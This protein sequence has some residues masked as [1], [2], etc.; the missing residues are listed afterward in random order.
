MINIH[1][2]GDIVR[3][4]D[5]AEIHKRANE[6]REQRG[7]CKYHYNLITCQAWIDYKKNEPIGECRKDCH[8]SGCDDCPG[9]KQRKEIG[10][11]AK[12][13][14][15]DNTVYRKISSAAH[16]MVKDSKYKTIF[17]TLTFPPY[18]TKENEKLQNNAF[19]KFMENLH[20]NYGVK[21]YIAIRERGK[22]TNRLHYHLLCSI[23]FVDFTTLNRSWCNAISDISDFSINALS[24]KKQNV[25]I[26]NPGYALRYACKYFSKQRGY[27]SSTRIVFISNSLLSY[28]T[29]EI[30]DYSAR[31]EPI[32]KRISKI[33]KSVHVPVTSILT[34]YKN[35][36]IQ[37]TSD[38]ST[39]F[40]ITD[41]LE[42][43]RFCSDFLYLFF[44][45]ENKKAD[46]VGYPSE[47]S[48]S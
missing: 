32:Y 33:K 12:S 24:S 18:K 31:G 36:Y 35:I 8:L 45:L 17:I 4:P 15:I 5:I 9:Y 41:K 23:K 13:Y 21:Y 46:F 14:K 3:C 39:C 6:L 44:E 16:Y 1:L 25:I 48:L 42:F 2:N 40:R 47:F 30:I 26:R 22:D 28:P 7:V 20:N 19:S 11:L 43:D 27:S 10:N 34:G 38:Y 29:K 37:Q